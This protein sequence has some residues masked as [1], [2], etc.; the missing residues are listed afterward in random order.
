MSTDVEDARIRDAIKEAVA[1]MRRPEDGISPYD[2]TTYREAAMATP[3]MRTAMSD[4]TFDKSKRTKISTNVISM[5]EF[6]ASSKKKH[7]DGHKAIPWSEMDDDEIECLIAA[8]T[9]IT[10]KVGH[11][12]VGKPGDPFSRM[13]PTDYGELILERDLETLLFCLPDHGAISNEV[14]EMRP[15]V[16]LKRFHDL[17]PVRIIIELESAP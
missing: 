9:V 6:K 2:D 14:Q 17:F 3:Q 12:S 7:D 16:T 8:I 15:A 11:S 1:D 5:S 10:V 4:G 13:W